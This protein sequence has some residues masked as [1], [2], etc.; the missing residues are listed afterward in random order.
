MGLRA[1]RW[2]GHFALAKPRLKFVASTCLMTT[3]AR[4]PCQ[5]DPRGITD[6]CQLHDWSW[7]G[8]PEPATA[9]SAGAL[10]QEYRFTSRSASEGDFVEGIRAAIIDKDRNPRWQS[11]DPWRR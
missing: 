7:C 5:G 8:A 6:I 11:R 10:R 9:P 4:R 3:G 2:I 1:N